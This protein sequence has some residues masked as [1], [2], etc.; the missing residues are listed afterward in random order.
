M[1]KASLFLAF[2]FIAKSLAILLRGGMSSEK[3]AKLAQLRR[4]ESV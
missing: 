3:E 4:W 1:L 2:V